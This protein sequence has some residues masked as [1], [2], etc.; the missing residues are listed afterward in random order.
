MKTDRLHAFLDGKRVLIYGL[1]RE[2]I[3]TLQFLLP[4]KS[5]F[6]HL[7][8]VDDATR[9]SFLAEKTPFFSSIDAVNAAD[10]D[11][12]F[13]APGVKLSRLKHFRPEQITSQLDLYLECCEGRVI[14]ITGT[15]GK[16]TTSALTYHVL[17]SHQPTL[18]VGNIGQP[19]LN[20]LVK[21]T[22]E[23][24]T[25][26]EMSSG[27]LETA[28]H[29][30]HLAVWLNLFPEHMDFHGSLEVYCA[31]KQNIVR[32]QTKNNICVHHV[33]LTPFIQTQAK[34]YTFSDDNPQ[35]HE[36]SKQLRRQGVFIHPLTLSCV[37]K[38]A[39]A[40]GIEKKF[41]QTCASYRPLNHRMEPIHSVKGVVYLDDMLATIPEATIYAL[42]TVQPHT[43]I[44]GGH[45]RGADYRPLA[46][47][48]AAT[49]QLRV[50]I[51]M[52]DTGHTLA[53][54][55]DAIPSHQIKIF[56]VQTADEAVLVAERETPSGATCLISPAA[57]SFNQFAN[58]ETKAA[59]FRE[60]IIKS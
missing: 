19:S 53:D 30:P 55:L 7:A 1:G 50:A 49:P 46:E 39:A 34:C 33:S 35:A 43:L 29:S 22:P 13:K 23:T 54:L 26:Y 12:V 21:T 57:A 38:I 41:E 20:Q 36:L 27:Q 45:D 31:A 42:G 37:Q 28:R 56:R 2:G 8:V 15:K 59:R 44:A 17:Q 32:H 40:F 47:A 58:Y 10:F 25:V 9:P 60:L 3:S 6:A 11:L 48:I 16:S 18:L 4:L 52:P 51:L 5:S 24:I 14:G